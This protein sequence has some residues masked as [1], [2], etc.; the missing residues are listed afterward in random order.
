MIRLT[1]YILVTLL[2]IINAYAQNSEYEKGMQKAFELWQ[3]QKTSE[4]SNLFERIA[5]AE[6]EN[7]IPYYYT[8]YINTIYSFG[9]KDAAKHH[10]QLEKAQLY[11]DK[12]FGISKNN[13]ELIVLQ[14][15]IHTAWIAFDGQTYGMALSGKTNQLYREALAIA[16]E[17]PRVL[18]SYAEWNMGSA[19][20]FGKDTTPYCK[21]VEKALQ[22]FV[23]FKEETPFYPSWGKSRAE[24]VL[25]SCKVE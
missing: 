18:L 14:A 25:A 2:G 15:L 13:P 9:E 1:F 7:W 3:Q 8:A 23:T 24:E 20:F 11:V 10:A 4:A 22:L 17:N 12:A 19:R 16:P 21:D 5:N 6:E